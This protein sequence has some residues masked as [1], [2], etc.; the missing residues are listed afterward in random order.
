MIAVLFDNKKNLPLSVAVMM[1]RREFERAE[2]TQGYRPAI[3]VLNPAEV[4][5]EAVICGLTVHA[6]FEVKPHHIRVCTEWEGRL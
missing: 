3:V 4:A 5:D 2:H 1:A 6:S